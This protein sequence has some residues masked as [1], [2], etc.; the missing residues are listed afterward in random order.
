MSHRVGLAFLLFLS[1]LGLLG[2]IPSLPACCPAPPSGKPV[3]N[4]DQTVILI[5]DA[6]TKTQHFIRKA[7]FKGQADDFGFLVPS[8]TQPELDESG[9]DAFPFLQKLT[10]PEIKRMPRPSGGLACGCA[11][12]SKVKTK[13]GP[14]G[15]IVLDEK[16]V[17]GFNAVVLEASSADALVKWL[18]EHG[19]AYSP[20][21]EAWAKPYV[22]QGWKITALKVARAKDEKDS[23]SVTAAALRISFK[24]EQP[25]FPYREPD[26]KNANQTVGANQR[27][28]RIYFVAEARY[29]GE[30]TPESPWTGKVAWADKIRLE[31]R[32]KVLEM[33]KLPETTGPA[34]WWMTEFEDNWPY[35]VAPV[36]VTFSYDANQ[37]TTK[38]PP[39][40]QYVST[41]PRDVMLLAL[42]AALVLP[43][44]FR[45]VRR[46]S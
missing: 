33:L 43:T 5:W 12:G 30:L 3:V 21:I 6:A 23:A 39:I 20:E 42:M 37:G 2:I 19:Y 1:L 11:S 35:R 24:T 28:L 18:K 22:E 17:A 32:K 31:D 10:E 15:V 16:L 13:N 38:R 34:E 40:I 25:L 45:L 27:L 8:P 26:Y 46:M 9:N 29:R 7:S 4:A 44:M 14:A 41:G 36:D